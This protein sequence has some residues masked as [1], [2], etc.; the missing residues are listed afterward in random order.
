MRVARL[1][2]RVGLGTFQPVRVDTTEEI[3][4]HAESYTLP[5]ETAEALNAARR[6]GRRVIAVGTTS[7]RTLEHI[8]R[9]AESNGGV[10]EAHSGST[11]LFLSP[12]AEFKIVGGLL[13]NFHLP[14]ST[15]LMELTVALKPPS[16]NRSDGQ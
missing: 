1:T 14:Q 10:I 3:R 11:S 12:G 16:A 13:T 5:A 4:L 15:L 6:E 7:T 2:L 8:A 9:E